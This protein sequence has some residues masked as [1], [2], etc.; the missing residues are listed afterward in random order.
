MPGQIGELYL[1][2]KVK[3]L[4]KGKSEID[5][6]TDVS[7]EKFIKKYG[8]RPVLL[9]AKE[10][11]LQYLHPRKDIDVGIANYVTPGHIMLCEIVLFRRPRILKCKRTPVK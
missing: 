7:I 4:P 5:L 2:D 1:I 3:K 6:A 11:S 9:L 8:Y 10:T